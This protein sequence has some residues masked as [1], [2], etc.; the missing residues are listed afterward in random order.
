MRTLFA[1][2]ALGCS[3]G[4][5]PADPPPD[6]LDTV[7]V[8]EPR[9]ALRGWALQR[10][11]GGAFTAR[12]LVGRTSLVFVGY[13]RCPDVCPNTLSVLAGVREQAPEVQIVFLSV[14]PDHDEAGLG[15]YLRFFAEGIV[16]VTGARSAIDHAVKQLGASY[17]F[18][19]GLVEHSTSLF[20]VDEGA[21]LAGILLR[22]STAEG[23]AK[24]LARLRKHRPPRVRAT[25][26]VPPAPPGSPGVAY[27]RIEATEP[28][29]LTRITSPDVERVELHRTVRTA[30]SASM[31]PVDA[32]PLRPSTPATLSPGGL[33]LM[34]LGQR[35]TAAPLL[36]LHFVRPPTV[37]VA[38]E[39][40]SSR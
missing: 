35:D 23:V 16:G 17:T 27:G 37:L 7:Q 40:A 14:D 28:A 6:W 12:D 11:G 19:E 15:A 21:N 10:T 18:A 38:A 9:R 22:P 32:L 39:P 31:I 1:F 5:P 4:A 26:E 20:V 36:E 30:T 8:A 25:L 34:L 3:F 33:H 24:D 29:T 13:T 2:T